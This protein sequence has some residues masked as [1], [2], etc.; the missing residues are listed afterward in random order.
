MTRLLCTVKKS[1]QSI[2]MS[3]YSNSEKK[4][5]ARLICKNARPCFG[6]KTDCINH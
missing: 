1:V 6:E 2:F 4:D 3:G 5:V